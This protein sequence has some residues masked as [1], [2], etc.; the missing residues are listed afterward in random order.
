[1]IEEFNIEKKDPMPIV[2][3][4]SKFLT[5]ESI[6]AAP[7]IE[8]L[9]VDMPEW[10]GIV[11]IKP[12]SGAGRDAFEA[13]V[14]EEKNGKTVLKSQNFRARLVARCIVDEDGKRMFADEDIT[15]LGRKSAKALSRLFD[16]VQKASGM[17]KEDVAELEGNSEGQEDDSS[18]V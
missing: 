4:K 17:T 2:K 1:M 16:E 14:I 6:L 8:T 10:G 11:L 3:S 12:L 7:D 9:E 5:R 18:S 13:S 15:S